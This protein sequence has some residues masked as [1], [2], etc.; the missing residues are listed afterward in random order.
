MKKQIY[1]VH[2]G[3]IENY[4]NLAEKLRNAGYGFYGQTDSEV[5]ANLI[6]YCLEST[7]DIKKAIL[8][9]L[10][11]VT[12]TYGLAIIS[13]SDPTRLYAVRRGSP[14]MI[15][16]IQNGLMVASDPHAFPEPDPT[17]IPMEDGELATLNLDGTYTIE[18]VNGDV[19]TRE[20]LKLEIFQDTADTSQYAH[21]MLAEIMEQPEVIE[22]TICGRINFETEQVM[23]GGIKNIMPEL[24]RKKEI[25]IVAC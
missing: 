22:N 7:K 21:S 2:N 4:K 25:I 6:E 10:S 18:S 17:V 15:S 24:L 11:Q 14:L 12:G 3:I 8:L 20:A 1:L 13:P 23:L 16:K 5:L 19:I 9:A